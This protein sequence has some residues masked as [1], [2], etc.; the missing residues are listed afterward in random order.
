MNTTTPVEEAVAA[1]EQRIAQFQKYRRNALSDVMGQ[2][3]T[4]GG[5][6]Q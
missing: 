3:A 5:F 6:I 2:E 1:A 4:S